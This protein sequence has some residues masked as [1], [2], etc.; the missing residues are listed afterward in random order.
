MADGI[1]LQQYKREYLLLVRQ[2]QSF[3]QSLLFFLM[4]AAFFPLTLPYDPQLIRS[5]CPGI[6]W[7]AVTLAVFLSA[8]RFYQ[9]DIEYGI[10]EQWLVQR[11]SL[12]IYVLIKIVVHG[13]THLLAI[14]TISPLVAVLFQLNMHEWV[15]MALGLFFGMPA[16]IGMCALVSA[17]GSY[18]QDRSLVMLL[19]LFPLILPVIMLGSS[20]LAVVMQGL[21]VSGYL[22]LLLALSL[23]T[24][25]VLPFATG[26][27]LKTCMQQG[28]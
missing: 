10:L 13:L 17:F 5:L 28:I 8:E 14:L 16:L 4:F 24:L 18:G 21:P 19:I 23:G 6:I 3:V 27:I 26:L 9:Q 1:M 7:L 20:S 2:K 15:V 25:L 11:L 22:A 12:S